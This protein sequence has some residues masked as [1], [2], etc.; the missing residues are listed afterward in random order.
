VK[1]VRV[2]SLVPHTHYPVG[3]PFMYDK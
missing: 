3:H 1:R 2:R